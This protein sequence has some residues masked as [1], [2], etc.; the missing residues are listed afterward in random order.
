M[1]RH[2]LTIRLALLF[3]LLAFAVLGTVGASLYRALEIQL[4]QRDDAALVTRVD[5]IRTLL[6]DNNALQMIH[7][8]PRLFANMLGNREGLL[9]L[10]FEGQP[11]L[12]EI[13]PSGVPLPALPPIGAGESLS[14]AA[15]KH[16]L[17]PSGTPFSAISASARTADP[18]QQLEIVAGRVMNERTRLLDRYRK[19][20]LLLVCAGSLLFALLGYVLVR[21]GL[22]PLRRLALHTET[23]G[24]ANLSARIDN[25]DAPLELS[26]LINAFNAML[27]RLAKAFTQLSQVSTDM[28]HDLR[29]P[30]NN[31][32][33]QTQVAL[34]QRR[35]VEQYESLLASNV[36]ELERLSRMVDNMLFLAR[37]DHP[38]A[39]RER[40]T[41]DVSDEFQRM[42]DYFEGLAGEREIAITLAGAGNVWA[43]P[44]L[45]RRA[46]ANLLSNAVK[47]AD[48]NTAILLD[49]HESE[50]GVT[51]SVENRGATIPEYHLARLFDRFYRADASRG[52]SSESNG[53]GLSIVRTIMQ[54]HNG[55]YDAASADGATRFSLFFPHEHVEAALPFRG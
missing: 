15:V 7:E 37:A 2:S 31:L 20:I 17:D 46:L 55:R 11:P 33:G 13:N 3:A 30:I 26:P 10:R 48:A 4:E 12:I 50:E 53:L 36:E 14:P 51:L 9:V 22:G 25:A 43:D 5:Q 52:G 39:V 45:L 32:L 38:Q 16:S 42:A 27:D 28:A 34:G 40:K 41:L 49:A 47:Y 21:R 54:L 8:R 24:V 19:M 29:T 1:R 35:N 18:G 6:Q 23:I 44:I